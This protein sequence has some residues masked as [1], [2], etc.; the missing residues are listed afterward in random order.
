M[1]GEPES[2][3]TPALGVLRQVQRLRERFRCGGPLDDWREVED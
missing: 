3:I 2:P 1:F